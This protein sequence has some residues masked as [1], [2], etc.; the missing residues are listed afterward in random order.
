MALFRELGCV[1]IDPLRAVER[2][3]LLVLW[4]R[5]GKFDP[6]D[7]ETLLY[8][9]RRLFEYWAHAAS[10]VLTDDYPIYQLHMRDWLVGDEG[11]KIRFRD[12][13]EKNDELCQYI[14]KELNKNGPLSSRHFKD[15]SQK[16]WE[17]SGWTSGQNVSQMLGGLWRLGQIMVHSRKGLTK[18]YELTE[19]CLPDW[20]PR[21]E[22]EWPEAVNRSAQQSLRA[23]G[24]AKA[25]HINEHF[26]RGRY[27]NLAETL[28]QLEAEEKLIQ[29]Q[30]KED[31][32]PWPGVWYV[33]A[34]KLP[35]LDRLERGEWEPRTTLLSP[36]DN[37]ICDRNRTE[38]LFKFYFRIEIYVPKAKRE[39]GYYVLPILHGDR[40]I[41][42]LDPKM[43][44]KKKRLNI[45]AVYAEPEVSL[46]PETGQAV[47]RAIEELADFLGANDIVFEGPTPAEW[48]L[49]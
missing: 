11:W 10:I 21:E 8:Q 44:R 48:K 37:L 18:Y 39:Y 3:Q 27:P 25:A 15:Q 43:D 41:G 1:Q 31:G 17:S 42:R 16:S 2:T 33:H 23:L 30:I 47:L 9:E 29:V 28:A 34:D 24:L 46:D 20:T 14:L 12:W 35:L 19:R 6:A 7:L 40:L 13:M 38:E 4:S 32:E 49:T 26:S 5:L 36:F 22:L 45:Y